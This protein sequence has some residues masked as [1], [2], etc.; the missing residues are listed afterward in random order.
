MLFCLAYS[1]PILPRMPFWRVDM[2]VD[3][4]S[5]HF[6]GGNFRSTIYYGVNKKMLLS[7]FNSPY[8]NFCFTSSTCALDLWCSSPTYLTSYVGPT[9]LNWRNICYSFI[10]FPLNFISK[11][12]FLFSF[13]AIS[14]FPWWSCLMPRRARWARI[15]SSFYRLSSPLSRSGSSKLFGSSLG[16]YAGVSSTDNGSGTCSG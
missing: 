9:S 13:S 3:S 11:I 4:S 5:S 6:L 2:S 14:T 8:L 10:G 1:F 16:V 12:V 7:R 15:C